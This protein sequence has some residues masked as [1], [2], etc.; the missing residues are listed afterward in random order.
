MVLHVTALLLLVLSAKSLTINTCFGVSHCCPKQAVLDGK[1]ALLLGILRGRRRFQKQVGHP[2]AQMLSKI[3][4]CKYAVKL[5]LPD[6]FKIL[7]WTVVRVSPFSDLS[8][9]LAERGVR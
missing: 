2:G 5:R 1:Y 8:I 7:F 3:K 4:P 9:H 6:E